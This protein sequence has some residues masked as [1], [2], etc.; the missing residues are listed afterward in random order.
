VEEQDITAL[1]PWL[2]WGYQTVKAA[3]IK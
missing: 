2:D 1:L 3:R